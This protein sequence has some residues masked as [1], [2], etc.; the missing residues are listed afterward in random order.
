MSVDRQITWLE[1]HEHFG[2]PTIERVRDVAQDFLGPR[3]NVYIEG[4]HNVVCI[5]DEPMTHSLISQQQ[6]WD[7][8]RNLHERYQKRARGF[9][10]FFLDEHGEKQ[11]AVRTWEADDFTGALADR[12]AKILARFWHGEVRW[13]T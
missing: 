1:P 5:S 13:P 7:F 4:K 8:A 9:R 6:D 10:I 2:R 12:F 3:W 11:T